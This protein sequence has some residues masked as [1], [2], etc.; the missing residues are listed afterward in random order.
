[1][2]T[3]YQSCLTTEGSHLHV[4][5]RSRSSGL[6]DP[7]HLHIRERSDLSGDVVPPQVAPV[8]AVKLQSVGDIPWNL[9]AELVAVILLPP[10]RSSYPAIRLVQHVWCPLG[11]GLLLEKVVVCSCLL[12]QVLLDGR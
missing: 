3:R 8:L 4:V 11:E 10:S 12:S 7:E 5:A 9:N 6:E 2:T 1:M